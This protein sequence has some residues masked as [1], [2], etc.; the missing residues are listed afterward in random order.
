MPAQRPRASFE[1]I[2]PHFNLDELVETTDNFQY[3]DRLGLDV[4]EEQGLKRFEKLLLLRVIVG[5]MPLVIDGFEDKLDPWTF[6]PKWLRD[7]HGDKVENARDITAQ[8]DLPLTIGH[9]L[10]NMGILT[11]QYFEKPE[12]YK[13]KNRQ[14]I[15]LKDIDCPPVWQD[16]LR[17]HV[18]G[19]LFYWNDS[20]AE[21]GGLGAVGGPIHGATGRK[22]GKGVAIAGDLM[23][24]LPVEMR[25]ENLQ[26]YIGHEGTYTPAHR[27][28]CAT[29]GHNIMVNASGGVDEYGERE[30]PGSSVW[31]M[32]ESR[33]RHTVAEYWMSVLG[34]DIEIENHFAQMVAWQRAPFKV[35]VVEQRP[36]DLIL[37]PPLAPHQVWNRGTRTM[38]VAWNRT[39]VDTLELALKEALPKARMVCRDEQ[40]KNKA[41]SYYTLLKYSALFKSSATQL[42]GSRHDAYDIETYKQVRQI[43]KDS[44]RLFELFKQIMLSEMF[45][46]SPK[47][48]PEFIAFDSNV[49]CS[50]C[51]GN[52]FNR[53]LTCK[54]C[55]DALGTD[56]DEPYDVCMECFIMGRGCGCQSKYKWVEQFKWKELVGRYEEWRKQI[57]EM[58]IG[59]SGVAPMT[60]EKEREAYPK[61][62]L[63]QICQEQLKL[64]PWVDIKKPR[65]E[66]LDENGDEIR[67][68]SHGKVNRSGKKRPR[69]WNQNY[70]ACHSCAHRHPK[71]MMAICT[72]CERGLCYGFLWRAQEVMPQTILEDPNWICPHCR[73]ICN[74]AA[75]R[76]DSKQKPYQPKGT[77]L[78]HDT[79]KVA[80]PRSVECLVDFSVSNVKHLMDEEDALLNPRLLEAQ[81]AAERAKLSDPML[82]ER[83]FD[84]GEENGIVM[85]GP[86]DTRGQIEYSPMDDLID[87]ALGG[88]GNGLSASTGLSQATLAHNTLVASDP[89]PTLPDFM[90]TRHLSTHFYPDPSMESQSQ[91]VAPSAVMYEIPDSFGY[92]P[93]NSDPAAFGG[94]EKRPR[95]DELEEIKLVTSKRRRVPVAPKA[96]QAKDKA[97]KQYQQEHERKL[98]EEAKKNGRHTQ[99]FGKLHNRSCIAILKISKEKL[100]RFDLNPATQ[101]EAL[102]EERNVLLRSDILQGAPKPTVPAP[103]P[104]PVKGK[105]KTE[106]RQFRYRVEDDE[107]YGDRSDR[108]RRK[109]RYEEV[110]VESDIE[111][112]IREGITSKKDRSPTQRRRSTWLAR[113][114]QGDDNLPEELPPNFK[115]GQVSRSQRQRAMPRQQAQKR[116]TIR[117][118]RTSPESFVEY[119]SEGDTADEDD[120]P[121]S[122]PVPVENPVDDS[123][124]ADILELHAELQPVVNPVASDLTGINHPI[125]RPTGRS[126]PTTF[127]PATAHTTSGPIQS[128]LFSPVPETASIT[129]S[130]S[131]HTSPEPAFSSEEEN[132]QA[133]AI[134]QMPPTV[135]KPAVS[136]AVQASTTFQMP[137]TVAKPAV[138]KAVQVAKDALAAER[139]RA[140]AM[141]AENKWAR[142][143]AAGLLDNEDKDEDEAEDEDGDQDS[144]ESSKQSAYGSVSPSAPSPPVESFSK[145]EPRTAVM[146]SAERPAP[147]ATPTRSRGGPPSPRRGRGGSLFNSISSRGK[148]K[149]VSKAAS[150]KRASDSG[151]GARAE[152]PETPIAQ[153]SAGQGETAKRSPTRGRPP[154]RASL[155]NMTAGSLRGGFGQSGRGRGGPVR[156][157]GN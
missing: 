74:V 8:Q 128:S 76:K 94:S 45:A 120:R 48:H 132:V 119:H 13:D 101:S 134:F 78:G 95:A 2:S 40:Y 55:P 39:T 79:K 60:L 26:C 149:I 77:I 121:P 43:K 124:M 42:A 100:R 150:S 66:L 142:L 92:L 114:N 17:E 15:Y 12:N 19:S 20:I 82:D 116:P 62:T 3:V 104:A 93:S 135:A 27:E 129:Q 91:F 144:T 29:L 89:V 51:R 53:F 107:L 52:I 113:K 145:P 68:D 35:Y 133:S 21:A 112:A 139:E 70:Q 138:S 69:D 111:D 109:Q 85:N 98:L 143:R 141:E 58:G 81:A 34:H 122:P 83:Y 71:W 25:A 137:P 56:T 49:T 28:M 84:D 67:V 10:K 80:D 61:R 24:S 16:K 125:G 105:G 148:I 157:G 65:Q 47:E 110:T 152:T 153:A 90:S 115:D 154:G 46:P 136:K 146:R 11:E 23:S 147:V 127:P 6:T 108:P 50:Y 130:M 87:P 4:I 30:R 126:Q 75:C 41:I 1:P 54:T 5:G 102:A 103:D 118:A 64:R 9:Y 156:R 131:T 140:A 63:A 151:F 86:M 72:K 31:F 18:P 22:K 32:T 44:K 97:T 155:P 57:I 96:P 117:P 88:S 123:F 14:R 37:I 38:K 106:S 33:D 59:A 36:G 73:R 99:V 7:N